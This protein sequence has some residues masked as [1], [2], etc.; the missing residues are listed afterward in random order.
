MVEE[1]HRFGLGRGPQ[2]MGT[3]S[4]VPQALEQLGRQGSPE[5]DGQGGGPA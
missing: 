5:G 4:S 1:L 2:S 3:F